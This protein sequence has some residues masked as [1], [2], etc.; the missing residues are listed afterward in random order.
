MAY[1]RVKR[2]GINKYYYLVESKRSGEKV[3]QTY[4]QYLGTQKPSERELEQIIND[5][6]SGK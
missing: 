6:K 5:I 2:R 3:K 1:V 4:L